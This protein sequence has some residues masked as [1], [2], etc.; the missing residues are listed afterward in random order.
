MG[1]P[2]TRA[3][4]RVIRPSSRTAS[5]SSEGS[6]RRTTFPCQA[7][8]VVCRHTLEHVHHV[9]EFLREVR[10]GLERTEGGIA[11]F[12]VPDA[13]RV[14]EEGAFWDLY[15]EHC[16]YFTPGSLARAF[17]SAGLAPMRLERTFDD[18]YLFI[19][20]TAEKGAPPEPLP[21]ERPRTRSS[22]LRNAS[23][24]RSTRCSASGETG[25]ARRAN[26]EPGP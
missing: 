22:R 9:A 11:L 3:T 7:A 10:A 15:Y 8:A 24:G 4:A 16:S 14:L 20:A 26:A 17:R 1:S 12:E 13:W 2:S 5:R 21:G 6:S 25:F 19:T 23:S 18:Q